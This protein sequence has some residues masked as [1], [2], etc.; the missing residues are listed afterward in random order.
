[1]GLLAD[2][3][4]IAL[5]NPWAL[6]SLISRHIGGR[7]CRFLS[8]SWWF[9]GAAQNS[10]CPLGFRQAFGDRLTSTFLGLFRMFGCTGVI[11]HLPSIPLGATHHFPVSWFSAFVASAP[12]ARVAAW[13]TA[14]AAARYRDRCDII[15]VAPAR[16]IS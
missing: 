11:S 4:N 3:S 16:R 5:P 2:V 8:A 14:R 12:A 9:D 7:T 15:F 13:G 6:P 1:M 10:P